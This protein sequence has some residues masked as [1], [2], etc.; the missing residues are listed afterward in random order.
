[1]KIKRIKKIMIIS[2]MFVASLVGIYHYY[3]NVHME[4]LENEN[5]DIFIKETVN[6]S[7]KGEK[8]EKKSKA[9]KVINY[10]AVLEIPKIKLKKGLV[11]PSSSDNNVGKN[12]TILNPASMP[13]DD[14]H[15]FVLAAHS[16][17]S[18]V[19]YFDDLNK[20]SN[21]DLVYVYY[22]NAK[23]IYKI[24]DNYSEKKTGSIIIQKDSNESVIVL[25]SCSK[26]N[27]RQLI[28]IGK[29]IGKEVYSA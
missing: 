11:S 19:A 18:K 3:N 2:M 12:I 22:K 16:G 17:S 20:L 13:D 1:M 23:Y 14:N 4:N 6:G 5:A 21:S 9:N 25:T 15:T 10:I 8:E 26:S 28:Y 27:K 24:K 7:K 29:L